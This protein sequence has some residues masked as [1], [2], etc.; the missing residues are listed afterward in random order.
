MDILHQGHASRSSLI[1]GQ[2]SRWPGEAVVAPPSEAPPETG[3][4]AE[5]ASADGEASAP[6]RRTRSFVCEVP[7]RVGPAEGRVLQARLEAARAL[8]NASLCEARKRWFLLRQSRAYQ[9][10]RTS[11]KQTPE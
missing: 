7:L 6:R 3:A 5:A 4:S 1:A 8:Y 2:L 9:H 10:A 11:P